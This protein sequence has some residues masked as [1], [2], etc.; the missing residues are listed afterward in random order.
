[1]EDG[2]RPECTQAKCRL[3][4]SQEL[5]GG[6]HGVK[7]RQPGAQSAMWLQMSEEVG[8]SLV[9]LHQVKHMGVG[10]ADGRSSAL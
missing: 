10:Y 1:M 2:C 7:A 6:Y 5:R 3:D 9:Y 8:A 4:G